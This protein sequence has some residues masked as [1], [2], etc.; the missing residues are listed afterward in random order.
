MK[1]LSKTI[2]GFFATI[3]ILI[4]T[5]VITVIIVILLNPRIRTSTST[6]ID[7]S[8]PNYQSEAH[9]DITPSTDSNT[10]RTSETSKSEQIDQFAE[11]ER[12]PVSEESESPNSNTPR[13][14]R[15]RSGG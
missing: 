9:P 11:P 13:G 1:I 8:T 15:P 6:N 5:V 4:T 7:G 12:T 14:R 10:P 2:I 3:G